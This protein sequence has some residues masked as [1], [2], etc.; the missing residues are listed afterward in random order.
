MGDVL[1][2][3]DDDEPDAP[4]EEKASNV[5]YS[6]VCRNSYTSQLFCVRP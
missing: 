5:S 1:D 2:L 3:Q 4:G 6:G